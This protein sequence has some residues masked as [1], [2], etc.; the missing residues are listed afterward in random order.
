MEESYIL[1][2]RE[3]RKILDSFLSLLQTTRSM[4]RDEHSVEKEAETLSNEALSV[5]PSS[6]SAVEAALDPAAYSQAASEC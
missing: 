6:T 2:E 1:E 3:H 5:P 4:L